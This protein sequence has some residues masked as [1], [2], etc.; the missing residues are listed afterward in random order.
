MKYKWKLIVLALLL[1]VLMACNKYFPNHTDQYSRFIFYPFQSLRI[2][3]LGAIPVSIGDILYVLGGSWL[4]ITQIRW[5]YFIS[6]FRIY[7]ELLAMSVLNTI[8]TIV[9][10]YL[11][12]LL[13][14]GF[15]Y[16]QPP[17]SIYWSLE[18]STQVRPDANNKAA[19]KLWRTKDS[20]ALISFDS[21]LV[22]RLNRCAP[23]YKTLTFHETNKRA[24]D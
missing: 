9:F 19:I 10:V 11:F 4:L 13:G 22:N 15:N 5:V 20:L 1:L 18:D 23:C 8:N 24:K 17:L 3:I 6:H 12:F 2:F 14:W 21:F 16:N 7:K